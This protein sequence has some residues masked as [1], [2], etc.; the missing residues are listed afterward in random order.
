MKTPDDMRSTK[1]MLLRTIKQCR[2][3]LADD[4][5]SLVHSKEVIGLTYDPEEIQGDL[6]IF[7]PAGY[8]AIVLSVPEFYSTTYQLTFRMIDFI[9][10]ESYSVHIRDY[11]LNNKYYK[12]A[13]DV[14]AKKVALLT[15]AILVCEQ[16]NR[17][18]DR[19]VRKFDKFPKRQAH[20]Y[21]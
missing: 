10:G 15:E 6:S 14:C 12:Y 21:D 4:L 19:L 2:I 11:I 17:E 18:L 5:C 7:D 1:N 8:D 20:L 3:F 13:N 16:E 9:V